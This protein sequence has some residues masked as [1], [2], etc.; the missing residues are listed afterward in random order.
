[1]KKIPVLFIF[2]LFLAVLSACAPGSG[3]K[4]GKT[5]TDLQLTLPGPNPEMDKAPEGGVVAGLVTGLWHGIISPVTLIMSFFNPDVQ[6]YDVFNTGPLYNL[7]CL[8]GVAIVFLLLGFSGGR[9]R[10]H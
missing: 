2:A 4:L 6:M 3:E 1:M 7:G 9:G 10:R 5:D 8:I